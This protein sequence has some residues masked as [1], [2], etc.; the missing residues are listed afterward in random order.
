MAGCAKDVPCQV[1]A[2]NSE[3]HRANKG[4]SLILSHSLRLSHLPTSVLVVHRGNL[5]F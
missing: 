3:V 5:T 2:G 1:T 4:E